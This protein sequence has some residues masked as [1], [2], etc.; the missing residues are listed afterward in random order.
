MCEYSIRC[1]FVRAQ[2]K[3]V[4][5]I[6]PDLTNAA[7]RGST[8]R[9]VRFNIKSLSTQSIWSLL[10]YKM[11]VYE[12]SHE[13]CQLITMRLSKTKARITF[14]VFNISLFLSILV[15]SKFLS[16]AKCIRIFS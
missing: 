4:Q 12:K 5:Y 14:L 2:N 6:A 16:Y 11:V 8:G 7:T 15:V 13:N 3:I 9:T 1:A 10:K